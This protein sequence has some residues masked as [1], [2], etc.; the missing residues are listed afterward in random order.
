M[1]RSEYHRMI[2]LGMFEEERVELIRGMLVKMAPQRR[3]VRQPLR[4]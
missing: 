2:E 1:K 3:R 4:G